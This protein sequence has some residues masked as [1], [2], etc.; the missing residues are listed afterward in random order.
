MKPFASPLTAALVLAAACAGTQAAQT[1]DFL[2]LASP[3]GY[4]IYDQYEQG[5]SDAERAS[6]VPGAPLQL[7]KADDRLGDQITSAMRLLFDGRILY[8]LTDEKGNPTGGSGTERRDLLKGCG[9]AGDTVTVI[10]AAGLKLAERSA[11]GGRMVTASK[12]ERL[13]LVFSYRD[14]YY[15]LRTVGGRRYGWCPRLSASS[16]RKVAAA[17]MVAADTSLAAMA[18]EQ[19]KGRIASANETYRRY[20]EGFNQATG[21]AKSAP[22]W[23]AAADGAEMR[24]TLAGPRQYAEQLS[25]ST[26]WLVQDLEGILVGTGYTAAYENGE[27]AVRRRVVTP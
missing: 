11:G 27:V 1:A 12:G 21:E 24:W 16:W 10:A 7:V 8:I 2:L 17:A 9:V 19:L 5:L 18:R 26:R 20:F 22:L 14:Q 6:L 4:T 13:V 15:V 23:R 3:R 25:G